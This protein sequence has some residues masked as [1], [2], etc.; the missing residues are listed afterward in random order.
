VPSSLNKEG[1]NIIG[2]PHYL[3]WIIFAWLTLDDDKHPR[4]IMYINVRL[5]SLRFSLRKDILNHCN[6]SF[7]NH[8]IMCFI[9]NIYS[10]DCQNTLKY[11][12]NTEVNLNNI[13]IMTGDFNIRNNDWD[14]SYPYYLLHTDML[15]EV[16]DSFDLELS[17]PINLIPTHYVN[18]PQESNS[19]LNLM[20]LRIG[21]EEFN[22]H[23][24]LPDL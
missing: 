22:N 10:D 11:L 12:K 13:L 6:I 16:I 20:F 2:T 18:S 21:S 14:P 15:Q 24:I 3:S 23:I 7:F 5:I 17:M 4:V 9:L 19:I 1:E 8:S